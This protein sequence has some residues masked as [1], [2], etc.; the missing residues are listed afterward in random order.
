MQTEELILPGVNETLK[1]YMQWRPIVYTTMSRELSSS[2]GI[3][4]LEVADVED[5]STTFKNTMLYAMYGMDLDEIVV[6]AVNVSFGVKG[7]GFFKK[8][9]YSAW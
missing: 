4:V 5:A 9:N 3:E 2:T 7:D 8:T 1:S 6:K